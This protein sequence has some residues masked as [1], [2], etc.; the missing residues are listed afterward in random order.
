MSHHVTSFNSDPSFFS[1]PPLVGHLEI[2]RDNTG[3]R[4]PGPWGFFGYCF[5]C[6]GPMA[7]LRLFASS[8]LAEI[9]GWWSSGRRCPGGSRGWVDVFFFGTDSTK[10][11]QTLSSSFF[12]QEIHQYNLNMAEFLQLILV[13]WRVSSTGWSDGFPHLAVPSLISHPYWKKQSYVGL[14][15]LSWIYIYTVDTYTDRLYTYIHIYYIH[16][17]LHIYYR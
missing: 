14:M 1:N 12:E 3:N 16:I 5:I 8:N 4:A 11:S 13:Y 7:H 17:V 15:H 10:I 9:C 2:D 6:R